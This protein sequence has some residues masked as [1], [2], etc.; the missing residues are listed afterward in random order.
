MA[1]ER[2]LF[3]LNHGVMAVDSSGPVV[4]RE[5]KGEDLPVQL[6]LALHRPKKFDKSSYGDGYT[7]R[8]LAIDNVESRGAALY[9]AGKEGK[10]YPVG[11]DKKGVFEDAANELIELFELLVGECRS[12]ESNRVIRFRQ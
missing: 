9:L 10:I 5:G 12:S 3:S 4:V 2:S 6:F 1:I 7:M 8:V 11:R